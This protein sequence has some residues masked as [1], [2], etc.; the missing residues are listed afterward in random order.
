MTPEQ[1][2][3]GLEDEVTYSGSGKGRTKTWHQ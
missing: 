3:S 1:V 2:V